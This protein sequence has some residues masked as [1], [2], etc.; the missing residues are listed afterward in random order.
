MPMRRRSWTGSTPASYTSAPSSSTDPVTQPPSDSSCIRFRQ[1]RKVL[2]PQPDGPI[3]AVTVCAGNRMDTSFTT[4]RRPYSAVSRTASSWSRASAGCAMA[5]SHGPA[6]REGED[7]HET[8]EH[9]RR[10]PGG[11]VSHR[12]DQPGPGEDA[13]NDRRCAVENIRHEP[14]RPAEAP[15]AVLGEVQS[16]PDADRQADQRRQSDDDHGP[17]DRVRHTDARLA[18][19]DGI[20]DEEA[21]VERR[22]AFGD[23][24]PEDEDKREHRDERQHRHHGGHGPAHDATAQATRA[25]RARLPTAVPRATRQIMSRARAFTA[26]VITNRMR[27]TSNSAER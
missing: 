7:Q 27:P 11:E 23:Q 22:R 15:R 20:L 14:D 19:R 26:T 16:R 1:R 3:T 18:G 6:G 2:L 24:I 12:P 5:R 17:D 21:P 25:H 9:Q 4:A 13:D 10:G 8:H